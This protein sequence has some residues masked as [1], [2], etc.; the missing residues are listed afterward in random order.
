MKTTD[1]PDLELMRAG[2]DY[3]FTIS[4]RDYRVTVRPLTAT[5]I[6]SAASKAAESYMKLS[7]TE[8]VNISASLLSAMYHLEMSSAPDVGEM[9]KLPFAMLQK[10][11]PDEVNHLF[12]QYVRVTERVNPDFEEIPLDRVKELVSN[13]KKNSDKRSPLI[14]ISISELMAVCLS[15]L[16]EQAESLPAN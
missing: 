11:T 16:D 8:R 12:K 2:V 10:M 7:E 1:F 13:L 15:L 4:L 14:D 3:K 5:E 9:G 6:V